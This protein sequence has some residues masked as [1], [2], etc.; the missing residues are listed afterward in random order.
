MRILNLLQSMRVNHWIKNGLL[1]FPL[2]F[3][4]QLFVADLLIEVTVGFVAFS[5]MSSAMYI[6]N[7]IS[8]I[9]Y[10]R[11]HASKR[12]RPIASGLIPVRTGY[13]ILTI[14]TLISLAIAFW[15]DPDFG[16]VLLAYFILMVSYNLKLKHIAIAD[17]AVIAIGFILRIFSGGIISDIPVS[18]WLV[19]MT[20]LLALFLALGKRRNEIDIEQ[21]GLDRRVIHGYN[22]DFVD[23]SL[24]LFGSVTVVAYILYTISPEV[25]TRIGSEYVYLTCLP[26]IFGLLRYLQLVI[27]HNLPA[28]PVEVFYKDH[29]IKTVVAVW[30]VIFLVM[31][32]Y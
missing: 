27:V 6:L 19:L 9:S 16:W 20:F 21:N 29:F 5:L 15:L 1:F 32:Y 13:I 3:A 14:L 4:G 28:D 18:K 8:D 24:T 7:D 23:I 22:K 31:L 25:T 2:L 12:M 26:V 10:D 30:A 11:A 17:I